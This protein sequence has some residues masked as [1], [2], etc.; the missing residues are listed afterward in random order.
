MHTFMTVDEHTKLD[1]GDL[2]NLGNICERRKLKW[3]EFLAFLPCFLLYNKNFHYCFIML[4]KSRLFLYPD[5]AKDPT[6]SWNEASWICSINVIMCS[7][8]NSVCF[9]FFLSLS[10]SLFAKQLLT[11]D[12][13]GVISHMENKLCGKHEYE[14]QAGRKRP[15]FLHY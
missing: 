14:T 3:H 13:T 7:L 10:L 15:N 1:C 4:A 12:Y 8:K 5:R 2:F 6:T 9:P 11:R